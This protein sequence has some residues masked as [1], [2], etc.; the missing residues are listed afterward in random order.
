MLEQD[1]AQDIEQNSKQEEK[2]KKG[3]DTDLMRAK[4]GGRT[5]HEVGQQKIID[6][7]LLVRKAGWASP[8][9]IDM[10]AGGGRRGTASKLVKNQLA[11]EII[12]G[13]GGVKQIPAKVLV[14]TEAGCS[15]AE[16]YLHQTKETKEYP[17]RPELGINYKQLLHDNL[18]INLTADAKWK[19]DIYDYSFAVELNQGQK[20]EKIPDAAWNV[21]SSENNS[22]STIAVE[23]ELTLKK[24]REFDMGCIAMGQA[25]RSGK[26]NTFMI[27]SHAFEIINKYKKQFTPGAK[28]Q[29][30]AK[31]DR[32]EY[33]EH[34]VFEMPEDIAV[35]VLFK[36]IRL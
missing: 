33:Y 10:I 12:T 26:Y 23:I 4:L 5:T 13:S 3:G 22:L 30:W 18:I 31:N 28:L 36:H 2:P 27:V 24:G 34:K 25:L 7:L 15:I 17:R 16:P 29:M 11:R 8:S 6:A 20:G 35:R 19:K 1:N 9:A 14:L 21:V 32:R